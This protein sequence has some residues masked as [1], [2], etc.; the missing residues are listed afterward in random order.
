MTDH[1]HILED[2]LGATVFPGNPSGIWIDEMGTITSGTDRVDI[3]V[4][5]NDGT[6]WTFKRLKED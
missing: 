3:F 4:R 2:S 6:E 1:L 5:F